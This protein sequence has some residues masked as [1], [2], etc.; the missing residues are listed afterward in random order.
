VFTARWRGERLG[1][2]RLALHG[3]HNVRNALAAIGVLLVMGE[4]PLAAAAALRD[5][6][7]V[8]RRFQVLGERGGVTVVDDY[9]HHPTEVAATLT[10]ARAVFPDRRLVAAFQPHLYSRTRVFGE[11]LGRELARADVVL[12]SDVYPAREERIPGV[13]GE[14]VAEAAKATASELPV[15]YVEALGELADRLLQLLRP[16]DVLITIGAG[17][18]DGVAREVLV[19][20]E[21]NDVVA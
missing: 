13:S 16:G 5:F 4:D 15:Y 1:D 14:Q 19:R 7:G 17:D 9:A 18:V 3:A 10:A 11:Q 2:F 8:D 21:G 12:V 20:L 6:K